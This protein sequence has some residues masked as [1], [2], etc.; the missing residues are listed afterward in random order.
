MMKRLAVKNEI[1]AGVGECV[2]SILGAV[3]IGQ[4][5]GHGPISLCVSQGTPSADRQVL[6]ELTIK[7]V[8]K[9]RRSS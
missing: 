4:V 9:T 7:R 3:L 1:I 6:G 8:S 5:R 2:A